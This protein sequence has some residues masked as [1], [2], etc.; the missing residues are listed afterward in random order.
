MRC[1]E[2]M[3]AKVGGFGMNKIL[4]LTSSRADYGI[5]LPLIKKF[6][7]FPDAALD[8]LAFG[9]HLSSNHGNTIQ[10]IYEDGF[11]V[12]HQIDIGI[13]GDAPIDVS[14]CYAN[15]VKLFA[16]FWEFKGGAYRWVLVL[17]DRFE[18]A[19]AV[20]AGVPFNIPFVHLHAG[21]TTLGAIDNMYRHWITLASKK[22]YVSLE[23]HKSKV[24]DLVGHEHNCYVMGALALDN[25]SN[26]A[27]LTTD[28]FFEKWQIDLKIPSILITL[29]PETVAFEKN[30]TYCAIFQSVLIDLAKKYQLIITMP[31]MDTNGQLYRISYE[32]VKAQ[33]PAQVQLIEN[34]GT[35]SY[36]TAMRYAGLAL[37]NTSSGIIEAASF[38]RYH[39]NIGDRQNGRVA[40]E[41]VLHVPFN[42]EEILA[43]VEQFF[44]KDYSGGNI[45]FRGGAAE[46]IVKTL[47]DEE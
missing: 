24:R 30:K 21:D 39:V 2:R 35:Q 41:N 27:L 14:K 19:A 36:F 42:R 29:H 32:M 25:L 45:Y 26:L 20:A 22:Y 17:G 8:I 34:F 12:K 47:F 11:E 15:T 33:N 5:Y 46:L 7:Q 37:G 16:D 28:E 38:K 10:Q 23:Q 43:K 40:G 4:L 31:N 6:K 18:M 9:T 3:E 44:G 1:A 13:E